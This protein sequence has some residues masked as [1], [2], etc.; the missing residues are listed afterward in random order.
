MWGVLLGLLIG[1][2][3]G[4]MLAAWAVVKFKMAELPAGARWG[5]VWGIA[6]L[7]GIGFTMSLFVTNLAFDGHEEHMSAS[8]LGILIASLL[9]GIG[10]SVIIAMGRKRVGDKT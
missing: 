3:V 1:K 6:M 5:Q 10:G 7:C 9:S 2:P 4:V 8:K